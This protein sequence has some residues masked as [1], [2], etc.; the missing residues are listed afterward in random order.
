MGG[1]LTSSGWIYW[2]IISTRIGTF[3]T[4]PL[5]VHA[6]PTQ[7]LMVAYTV[8]LG[9]SIAISVK[10]ASTVVVDV[11]RAR[12]MVAFALPSFVAFLS[13]VCVAMYAARARIFDLFTD[14]IEVLAGC[15]GI[16]WKVCW[17]FF[18]VGLA[19]ILMGIAAGLGLQWITGIVTIVCI[20]CFGLPM[21]L[22]FGF[23]NNGGLGVVWSCF[24]LPTSS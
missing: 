12:R 14:E 1:I 6:V 20:W 16:W 19:G 11:D 13:C 3:G 23:I 2:E 17:Y 5:S 7:L 21:T 15:E 10:L 8:P 4:I 9:M 24:G 18:N 22:Y